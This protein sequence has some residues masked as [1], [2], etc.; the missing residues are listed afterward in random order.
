VIITATVKNAGDADATA[1]KTEFLLDG[2]IVL[3]LADTPAIA[4]GASTNVSVMNWDTRAVKGD[5]TIRVTADRTSLVAESNENNNTATL[6]V[7][8]Q[9][10]KVT[11]GSFEQANSTGSGPGAWTGSSTGAGTVSW[12]AGGSVGSRSASV[13][14]NGGSAVLSGSPTW[15]SDPIAVAGGENLS[16][17]VSVNSVGASSAPTAGLAYLDALGQVIG[18]ATAITAPVSTGGFI[19]LE[20]S[21]VIPAGVAQ[22]RV[23]LS[24][25]SPL[26]VATAGTVTFDDMGLYGG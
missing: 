4:A 19:T 11:N 1:S 16:L 13:T 2:T 18:V 5:H 7:T 24:G 10:N 17:R 14:G 26:D 15:T 23:V 12:S 3:G 8:V 6:I 22:V 21:V 9:G 20:S 25:F